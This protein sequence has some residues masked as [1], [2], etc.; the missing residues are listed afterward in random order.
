M[1]EKSYQEIRADARGLLDAGEPQAAFQALRP[2]LSHP[3]SFDATGDFADALGLLAEVSMG[4]GVDPL[5]PHCRRAAAEPDDVDALHDLGFELIEVGLDDVA[6]TVLARANQLAPGTH[7]VVTELV[8]ALETEQRHP[9]ACQVLRGSGLVEADG[10]CRYLLAFNLLMC[11]ELDE[12]AALLPGLRELLPPERAAMGD[13]IAG[14]LARA[15]ALGDRSALDAG[16]LRGW[17]MVIS[18]GLLTHLSPYGSE[19][20]RGRYAFVQDS[21]ALLL[22]GARR[23][24]AALDAAGMVPPEVLYLPSRSSE[25]AARVVAAQLGLPATPL[26][27]TN[28]G[29][30]GLVVSYDLREEEGEALVAMHPH[31]AGQVLFAHATSWTDPSPYTPDV[32]TFLYQSNVAPWGEQ[33]RVDPETR[34]VAATAPSTA[35]AA[36]AAAALLEEARG[37]PAELEDLPALEALV[38]GT[39]ALGPADAP[40]ML[41]TEGPRRKL[42]LGG[43]VRSNRFR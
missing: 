37:A 26:D 15:A 3:G 24:G 43:P 18:G 42:F 13:R 12:P 16:D 2:A 38:Q 10:L 7:R 5:V 28:P 35:S 40:G 21:A 22:E 30:P 17:H 20:M 6:A 11:G 25:I 1:D 31:R 23:L 33:L 9:E 8:H 34:E 4:L 29:R 32:T 27:P 36:E 39:V 41:R 14:M 19:V